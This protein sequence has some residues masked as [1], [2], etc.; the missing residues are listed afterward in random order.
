MP[1][2]YSFFKILKDNILPLSSKIYYY[3]RK[4]DKNMWVFGEW[5]GKRC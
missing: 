4:R 3:F 1:V 2:V 5:F